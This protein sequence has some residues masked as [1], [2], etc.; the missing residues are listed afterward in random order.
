MAS[1]ISDQQQ[2]E[3]FSNHPELQAL[4]GR[5]FASLNE[6]RSAAKA[7]GIAVPQESLQYFQIAQ[8]E[9][10]SPEETVDQTLHKQGSHQI[11]FSHN[12]QQK[13]VNAQKAY[14]NIITTTIR[15]WNSLHKDDPT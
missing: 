6:L 10:L 4:S 12:G 14:E 8:Q 13:T 5:P 2:K 11:H 9:E 7:R 3:F 1:N 15:D